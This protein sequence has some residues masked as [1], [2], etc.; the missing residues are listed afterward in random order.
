MTC[1]QQLV[2]TTFS[3]FVVFSLRG[4][5]NKVIITVIS[6]AFMSPVTFFMFKIQVQPFFD[7][8]CRQWK[9][10]VVVVVAVYFF[11]QRFFNCGK[12]SSVYGRA[13]VHLAGV[14]MFDSRGWTRPQHNVQKGNSVL[15]LLPSSSCL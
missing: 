1:F 3:Y 7:Q 4:H 2:F 6:P 13:L 9:F 11:Q 8:E 5:R 15:H 10:S 12:F 14:R